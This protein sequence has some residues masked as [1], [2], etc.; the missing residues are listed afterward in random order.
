MGLS[1]EIGGQRREDE[2]LRLL[3]GVYPMGVALV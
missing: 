1:V 3:E 2:Q